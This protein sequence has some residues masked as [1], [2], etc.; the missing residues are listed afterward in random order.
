MRRAVG[1]PGDADCSVTGIPTLASG[2]PATALVDPNTP[3]FFSVDK[4]LRTPYMQQWHLGIE[5][6]LPG[7]SVFALT[8]GGSKGTKLYTFFNG[9]QAQPTADPNAPTAPTAPGEECGMQ[10]CNPRQLQPGLRHRH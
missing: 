7:I 3:I 4:N 8:Y 5:K 2:F 9:N 6:E 10:Y 1:E